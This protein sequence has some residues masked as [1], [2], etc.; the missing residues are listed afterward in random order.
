[1]YR[2][3]TLITSSKLH[4]YLFFEDDNKMD[5]F[6]R[7]I[8]YAETGGHATYVLLLNVLSVSIS[9]FV[10]VFVSFHFGW[11]IWIA[12]LIAF[13]TKLLI[14][15]KCEKIQYNFDRAHTLINRRVQYFGDVLKDKSAFQ[16]GKIYN[17]IDFFIQKM[18][19][20]RRTKFRDEKNNT[21]R[22]LKLNCI[23]LGINK[24]IDLMCYA[25]IG[26]ALLHKGLT[27][28]DYA[29]FFAA[30]ARINQVLD[31]IK[32]TLIM[33]F[34][35]SNNVESYK[36][37]L[38]ECEATSCIQVDN[39][40]TIHLGAIYR[41][42][43]DNVCFR[44]KNQ[45]AHA[46]KNVSISIN[47]GE[48]IS[49]VGLNGAGKTTFVKLLLGLYKPERGNIYVNGCNFKDVHMQ[50]YWGH[51]SVVYQD[52]KI[53]P[54]TISDNILFG[55]RQPENNIKSALIKTQLFD[56]IQSMENGIKSKVYQS[57]Y[58][59]GIDLS[60]GE[61]QRI[62]ITRAFV[63]NADL[64]IFDEPS[65]A[66]DAIAEEYLYQ[67]IN[68]IPND[69]TV[70]FISH[71]LASVSSTNRVIMFEGGEIIGDGNHDQLIK[72]CSQYRSLYE[73]QSRRYRDTP[74]T[75]ATASDVS[76]Y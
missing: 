22:L 29:L 39:N 76:E 11:W 15:K 54:L 13:F 61:K 23:S 31:A 25:V 44:Y 10:L 56:K 21:I 19:D 24:G 72:Q 60:G 47:K 73:T 27:L 74:N 50:D 59:D 8:Q 49:L 12:F 71:R 33:Y 9:S 62:A 41:I 32:A 75:E 57:Y 66:L 16:E 55:I 4:T 67:I 51:V 2:L 36:E 6:H 38:A 17:S 7:G 14:S 1:M 43:F 58:E 20:E 45:N 63:K 46:I 3:K 35:E 18:I 28:G 30:C 64:Y 5:V 26:Y 48:R 37:F 65:S 40:K 34:Q 70:I 42:K 68:S 53:Y 69:K 52:Y